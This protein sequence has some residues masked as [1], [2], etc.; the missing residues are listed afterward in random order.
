MQENFIDSW[1]SSESCN[2]TIQSHRYSF[3]ATLVWTQNL[4]LVLLL[5][6]HFKPYKSLQCDDLPFCNVILFP[7][8]CSVLHFLAS[9]SRTKARSHH[10]MSCRL[11]LR[12]KQSETTHPIQNNKKKTVQLSHFLIKTRKTSDCVLNLQGMLLLEGLSYT[13]N[14]RPDLQGHGDSC[15]VHWGY[16]GYDVYISKFKECSFGCCVRLDLLFT[17]LC[18]SS[19]TSMIMII[20][21]FCSIV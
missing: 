15:L 9:L 13:L 21:F 6:N 4:N 3:T 20:F 12:Q 1:L 14:Q 19:V 16:G 2:L 7:I 8:I 11:M 10:L 18:S 5:I 17:V